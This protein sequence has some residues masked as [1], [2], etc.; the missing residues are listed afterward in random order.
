MN[1]SLVFAALMA[2]NATHRPPAEVSL[3][4]LVRGLQRVSAFQPSAA[5]TL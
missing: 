3:W 4:V 5:R 1:A 2:T